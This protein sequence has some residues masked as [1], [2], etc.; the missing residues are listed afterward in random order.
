MKT[1]KLIID[2]KL[3][4]VSADLTVLQA[5]RSIGV[6]I[7]ALCYDETLE[8]F[9]ACRMCVVEVEGRE[10][11]VTACSQPVEEWMKIKTRLNTLTFV[12]FL[13]KI[14]LLSQVSIQLQMVKY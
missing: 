10:R 3:A 4:E 9:G 1:V 14:L 7:P 12:C 5:A 6:D 11:L 8:I 2:G 13:L